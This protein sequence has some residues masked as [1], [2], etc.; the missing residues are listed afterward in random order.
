MSTTQ[1]TDNQGIG[2]ARTGW[3]QNQLRLLH[4]G[5]RSCYSDACVDIQQVRQD[6]CHSVGAEGLDAVWSEVLEFEGSST[7]VT[8]NRSL[9]Q[10]RP[11]KVQRALDRNRQWEIT[12]RMVPSS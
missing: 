7:R 12:K 11:L 8:E 4:V 9:L 10:R 5:G 2:K 3:T 1:E 6:S